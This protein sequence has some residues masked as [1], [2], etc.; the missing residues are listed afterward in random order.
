MKVKQL[1]KKDLDGDPWYNFANC[2]GI[3]IDV[4][5]PSQYPDISAYANYRDAKKICDNCQVR[6]L[7]LLNALAEEMEERTIHGMRGGT[8]PQERAR[9][10]SIIKN[11]EMKQWKPKKDTAQTANLEALA[12]VLYADGDQ[13]RRRKWAKIVQSRINQS[14]QK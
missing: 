5:Y 8:V 13:S 6:D 4:F 11:K 10:L 7:C 1:T 12:L 2:N 14:G 9:L 3:E